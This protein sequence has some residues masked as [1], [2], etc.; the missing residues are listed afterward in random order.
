MQVF[1][2]NIH[3]LHLCCVQE[4]VLCA[5]SSIAKGKN[6]IFNSFFIYNIQYIQYAQYINC[7]K[8]IAKAIWSLHTWSSTQTAF[9]ECV[10]LWRAETVHVV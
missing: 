5:I 4:D 8:T 10:L 2:P 7:F 1:Q 3:G 9:A 6:D